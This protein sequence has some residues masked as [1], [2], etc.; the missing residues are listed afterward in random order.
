MKTMWRDLSSRARLGEAFGFI[1]AIALMYKLG[2]L[3]REQVIEML[4]QRVSKE[5]LAE[6]RK[7]RGDDGTPATARNFNR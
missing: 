6:Y 1:D 7:V 3:S 2:R 5:D 4:G